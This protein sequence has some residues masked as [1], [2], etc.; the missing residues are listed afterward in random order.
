[1]HGLNILRTCELI[2]IV[3]PIN[4]VPEGIKTGPVDWIYLFQING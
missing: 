2:F 3:H 1:M 4:C